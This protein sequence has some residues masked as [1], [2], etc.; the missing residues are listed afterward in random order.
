MA[1]HR[2]LSVGEAHRT[3]S[4]RGTVAQVSPLPAHSVHSLSAPFFF[5]QTH[6]CLVS[7]QSDG[8]DHADGLRT[9]YVSRVRSVP[10]HPQRW[11]VYLDSG[12]LSPEYAAVHCRHALWAYVKIRKFQQTSTCS[13]LS[14]LICGYGVGALVGSF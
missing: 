5:A 12:C 7:A 3:W 13:V 4:K 6:V 8:P 1:Y 11:D 2:H 9:T 14:V 10:S